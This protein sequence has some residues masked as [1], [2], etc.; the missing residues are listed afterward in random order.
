M[1]QCVVYRADGPAKVHLTRLAT[2]CFGQISRR[3]N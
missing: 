1:K 2:P 3:I